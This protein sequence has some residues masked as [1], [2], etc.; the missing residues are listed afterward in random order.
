MSSCC[1]ELILPTSVQ[2]LTTLG[3][4]GPVIWL[5]TQNFVMGQMTW[6]RPYQDSLSY[7]GCDLHIQ[8]LHQIFLVFAIANYEDA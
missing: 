3:S 7:V 1:I 4:A 5:E 6:P 8:P 2:N